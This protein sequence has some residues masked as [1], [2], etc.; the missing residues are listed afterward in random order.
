MF[1]K[2]SFWS[3]YVFENS[4]SEIE[5]NKKEITLFKFLKI[6]NS[7]ICWDLGSNTGNYSRLASQ[8]CE[9]VYGFDFD[10][11]SI[12]EFYKINNLKE[13]DNVDCFVCDLI[14]PSP[15]IGWDNKERVSII[16][17]CNADT[18]MCLALIHHLV[19]TNN[20]PIEM[21]SKQL[22]KMTKF[23]IIEFIP[24]EDI[25]VQKLIAN[26]EIN[27]IYSLEEFTEKFKLYFELI[28][29]ENVSQNGRILFLFKNLSN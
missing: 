26:R 19:I 12:N 23:L 18:I 11:E 3:N 25:Q 29:K 2:K 4:Y 6:A 17:R 14:N 24:N 13:I 8:V 21:I 1:N 22:S 27:Q 28:K 9:H 20:I 10:Y 15:S 5:K 16:K 7:K